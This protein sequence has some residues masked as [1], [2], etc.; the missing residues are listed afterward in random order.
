MHRLILQVISAAVILPLFASRTA[1]AQE[2]ESTPPRPET[3][4]AAGSLF[5]DQNLEQLVRKH[6]FEKRDNNKP[7]SE[8][9]VDK[10]STIEGKFAG[11]TNLAG[12]EKC[13]A[14]ASLDLAGNRITQLDALKDLKS[15]QYL[16][17]AGNRISDASPLAGIV[18]LQYLELSGNQL[19]DLRPLAGLT[20]LTSLYLGTN[21]ITDITP[22]LK[23][24]RV[25]TLCLE[26]NRLTTIAGL[27]QLKRLTSLALAA[28]QIS[29]LTPL[30]GLDSLSFLFLENNAI[31]DFSPLV[32][33]IKQDAAG[34]K[35]F[36]PY[37]K[38]YVKGNPGAA[39][40][41]VVEQY[42][43]RLEN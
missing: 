41:A 32:N 22:L 16:N 13:R 33:L 34:P 25:W 26:H 23:L 12:L 38:L 15:L 37:L 7:L 27:G 35:R 20:N 14:L 30:N 17:L 5:P 43:V 21:Q 18:A 10:L 6:V 19:H 42:G 36:A 39:K 4:R 28:N 24:D 40:T 11:I 9:D 2:Q 8:A 29:D 31:K 3:A 1:L